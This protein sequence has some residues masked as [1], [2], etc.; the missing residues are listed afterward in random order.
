MAVQKIHNFQKSRKIGRKAESEFHELFKDKVE[1]LDGYAADFQV[2]RNGK[3][4]ELKTDSHDPCKLPNFFME[5]YS[6]GEE[7]GGVWQ[8]L[9]KGTDYYVYWFPKTMEFY[10]YKVAS[11]VAKLEELYPRPW[12]IN[13]RNQAHN[14]RGFLVRR[15]KLDKIRIPLEDIL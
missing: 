3:T 2:L 4:I 12:L 11:L 15:D 6:Y 8:A 10:V 5:R 1:R 7:P 13:I 9:K 14:T